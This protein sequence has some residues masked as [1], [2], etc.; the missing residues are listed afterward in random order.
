MN[1]L[2]MVRVSG[3]LSLNFNIADVL[4]LTKK[5]YM[6]NGKAES[7]GSNNVQFVFNPQQQRVAAAFRVYWPLLP[8]LHMNYAAFVTD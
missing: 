7:N 6:Q 5:T 8:Q 1:G 2:C 4:P 3:L